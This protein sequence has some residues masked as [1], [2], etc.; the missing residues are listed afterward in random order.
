M[1]IETA[2]AHMHKH[3]QCLSDPCLNQE[4]LVP[5]RF[6]LLGYMTMS[7]SYLENDT[8]SYEIVIAKHKWSTLG[9]LILDYAH[10]CFDKKINL[11][12][13]TINWKLFNNHERFETL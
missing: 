4:L 12:L 3:Q 7:I 6:C 9:T 10:M 11:T 5:W 8:C 2:L 13:D 1:M